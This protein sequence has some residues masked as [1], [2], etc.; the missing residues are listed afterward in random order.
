MNDN[1]D[2]I[3]GFLF[4]ID[5]FKYLYSNI[6]LLYEIPF[7]RLLWKK[8]KLLLLN[9]WEEIILKFDSEETGWILTIYKRKLFS[10]FEIFHSN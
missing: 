9:V 8:I 3:D 10:Q 7:T 4:V 1:E 5:K 6:Q 2:N